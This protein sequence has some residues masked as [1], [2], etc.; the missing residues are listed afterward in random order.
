[1]IKIFFSL[2][3]FCVAF[4]SNALALDPCTKEYSPI[5]SRY[6]S[7][8]AFTLQKCGGLPSV[9]IGTMHSDNPALMQLHEKSLPVLKAARN[10]VFEI[11]FD[12]EAIEKTLATM[13]YSRASGKTLKSEAGADLHK[14]FMQ[15][16]D[17]PDPMNEYLKPWSAAIMLQ[18]PKQ[19]ADGVELDLK[20]Q[21]LAQAN[22][23]NIAGLEK[24]EEQLGIFDG[25]SKEDQIQALQDVLDNYDKNIKMQ[26]KMQSAY[27]A[28]DL[29]G[30]QRLIPES[31]ALSA[32]KEAAKQLMKL[33]IDDRNV[34]MAERSVKYLDEGNAYIA[35][36][37]LHLPGNIGVLKLLEDKGYRVEVLY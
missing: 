4:T 10:A 30:L 3:I 11:R 35:I 23:A 6:R 28:K 2:F 32:D 1:M 22:G 7:G 15:L 18:Y 26:N 25:M 8:I 37:A 20:L 36:G 24:V 19:V 33:L 27:M 9:I 16:V 13:F 21:K 14:R 31:L 29:R 17:K 34:R 5:E 12:N